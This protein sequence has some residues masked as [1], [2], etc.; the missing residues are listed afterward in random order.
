MGGIAQRRGDR[1]CLQQEAAARPRKA[2]SMSCGEPRL[3]ATRRISPASAAR[4][5]GESTPSPGPSIT[6]RRSL[7]PAHS[8]RHRPRRPRACRRALRWPR[9]TMRSRRPLTGSAEKA[10]PAA[11]AATSRCTITAGAPPAR[12][13]P[14]RGAIGAQA[15]GRARAPD[16]AAPRQ[17]LRRPGRRGSRGTGRHGNGWRRPPRGRTSARR[18]GR[19]RAR[20]ASRRA[21]RAPAA[22]SPSARKRL[23]QDDDEGRHVEAG[24]RQRRQGRGLAAGR[25]RIARVRRTQDERAQAHRSR[26]QRRKARG[27]IAD[28]NPEPGHRVHRFCAPGVGFCA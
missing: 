28:Q 2:H 22:F 20:P 6:R 13:E 24:R 10:T 17:R 19:A 11:R 4:S 16:L 5:A 26:Q 15:L 8:R 18:R 27:A 25:R 9:S 21:P 1:P 3:S 7:H 12:I 14:A 23:R